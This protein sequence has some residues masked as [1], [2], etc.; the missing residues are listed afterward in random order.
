MTVGK[1]GKSLDLTKEGLFKTL[2]TVQ[3]ARGRKVGFLSSFE[4]ER[5]DLKR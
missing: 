4:L 2:K 1:G 3:E 5:H